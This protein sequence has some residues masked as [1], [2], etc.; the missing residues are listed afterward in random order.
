[1]SEPFIEITGLGRSFG[2]AAAL[3]DINLVLAQGER[4]ALLGPNGAGKST[5]LKIIGGTLCPDSGRISLG[6]LTPAQARVKPGFLGWLPERAPLNPDL[7]VLEHLKLTCRFL[8]LSSQKTKEEIDFLTEALNLGSKLG[9]LTGQLSLGSRRQAALAVSLLGRPELILLDEPSSSL[10]PDEVRR[11]RDLLKNLPS[12]TTC[13]ISSHVLEEV[14]K[15]TEKALFI[16]RGRLLAVKK[17][18]QLGQ[19][20]LAESYLKEIERSANEEENQPGEK[21]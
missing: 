2:S 12:G 9:R 16:S 7:T 11:L 1:M 13:I 17:W 3:R 10:D 6:G 21:S 19:G 5:L 4:V 18:S 20:D 14:A 15:V 8:N